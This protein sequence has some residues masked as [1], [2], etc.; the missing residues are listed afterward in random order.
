M[1]RTSAILFLNHCHRP[2][3]FRFSATAT[4]D[5]LFSSRQW[6]GGA[7]AQGPSTAFL[8]SRLPSSHLLSSLQS[9]LF[10]PSH[11]SLLPFSHLSSSLPPHLFF[12]SLSSRLLFLALAS[13]LTSPLV[14]SSITYLPSSNFF[15]LSPLVFPSLSSLHPPSF[16]S[17]LPFPHLSLLPFPHL[18]SSP[19]L[20]SLSSSQELHSCFLI[21]FQTRNTFLLSNIFSDKKYILAF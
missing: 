13:S 2:I 8:T 5:T 9:P 20:P 19:P 1:A 18:P 10:F 17:L 16:T 6:C 15:L 21:Y 11:T 7:M 4:C 12:P 14:F 3:I